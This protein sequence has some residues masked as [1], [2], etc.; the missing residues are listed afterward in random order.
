[1]RVQNKRVVKRLEAATGS[2][3]GNLLRH[4]SF[5]GSNDLDPADARLAE[6]PHR[7]GGPIR[8]APDCAA[9]TARFAGSPRKWKQRM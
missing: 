9:V 8:F 1:M 4:R 2:G 3:S 5:V 6:S 7:G